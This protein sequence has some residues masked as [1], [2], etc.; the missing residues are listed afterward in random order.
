MKKIPKHLKYI[1]LIF[2]SL[3]IF[4]ACA[5]IA[6]PTGGDYDETP[7]KVLKVTPDFNT[8]NVKSNKIEI[9]FDENIKIEKANEKVIITPPQ[10]NQPAIKSF[11]KRAVVEL[12]D[13]L[14]KNTTY[15]IDFTDAI[16][17]YNESNPLENFS[18]SFSTGD[19]L[20][21]LSVS[22]RVLTADNLEPVSGIYIGMHTNLSDTAFTNIPFERISRTNSRGVFTVKSLAPGKYKIFALNDLN[23]DYKYDN[24]QEEIAF[25]D[26]IVVPSAVTSTKLDTIFTDSVTID[27]IKNISVTKFLPDDLILRTF[28][29]DFKRQYFQ[30]SERKTRSQL[31]FYFASPTEL[32]K[33][34]LLEP[35][36]SNPDWYLMEKSAKNDTISLWLMDSLVI[37]EDSIKI[38]L[39]YLSTDIDTNINSWKSDTINLTYR[40]PR[41]GRRDK[42]D[43]EIKFLS[44]KHNIRN[45]HEVYDPINI[46]FEYPVNKFEKNQASLFQLIDSVYQPINYQLQTDS[47]NPRKFIFHHKWEP[48]GKY[49]FAIDSAAVMSYNNLW[50]DKLQQDFAVKSLDQ[51]GNIMFQISGIPSG[52]TAYVELLDK[53]DKPFRKK[54]VKDNE[55]LFFDINPGKIY[56]RLFIDDNEDGVWTTGDYNSNRQPEEVYY[57][58]RAYEIRAYTDHEEAWDL[59]VTPVSE[60]KPLDIT[61]NKPQERK[62]RNLREE[63]EKEKEQ[64]QRQN[65]Q[66]LFPGMPGGTKTTIQTIGSRPN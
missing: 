25:L 61:K 64:Q 33:F 56:A 58:P 44:I 54:I 5:N 1:T 12:N 34:T 57:Y 59:L 11:G 45:N 19:I 42:E 47:L 23:R 20:D 7:P 53:S 38:K 43:T 2:T 66:G 39:D 6:M 18:I 40:E 60:Q 17:D 29:S 4:Y 46:E 9:L 26:S 24:P 13:S 49:R 55:A 15:T 31:T 51:Y 37:S 22:G 30:K 52:K 8:L 35:K 3:I 27:T 16:V 28:K 21:T 32:S 41:K 50:N 10:I 36:I 65:Q 62:K 63:R 14:Q 48:G